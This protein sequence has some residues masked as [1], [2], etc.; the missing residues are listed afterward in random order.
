MFLVTGIT[1]KVGGATADALLE[2]GKKVRAIVRDA[3]KA[4]AW[5]DKGVDL[6][7]GAWED[8]AAMTLALEGVEGAYLM[9]P[10]L[11]TPSHDFREAKA[12]IAGYKQALAAAAPPKVVALSSMGSEKDSGL[13]LITATHLM[14]EA[15]QD[16]PFSVA[17]VRA[18]SF[19]ENYLFGLQAAAG[20]TFPTFYS[21]TD[22]K[23]PM[24]AT[25]DIGAEIAQLL[26]SD[27]TGKRIIDLGSQVSADDLATA[28]G[29][30]LGREVR[31][32]AIPREA[33]PAALQGMGLPAGG[34]WAYEEMIDGVNS[35][36]IGFTGGDA[37]LVEG[38]TTARDVFASAKKY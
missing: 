29:H 2:K 12:V 15:L 31:A 11:Q 26:T 16:G 38:P 14:E 6:I 8:A 3:T 20:G 13:G 36:W 24:V 5:S 9:M 21:P 32:Q 19:Y 1:G 18:G 22:R 4:A 33:W 30:V 23:V 7:K 10:P 17:F 35:G 28:L 25:A 27:W 37:E 34:T